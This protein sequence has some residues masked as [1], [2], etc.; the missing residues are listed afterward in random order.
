ME[1]NVIAM[2]GKSPRKRAA[3]KPAAEPARNE[4]VVAKEA[5]SAPAAAVG[6]ADQ[7]RPGRSAVKSTLFAGATVIAL[8]GAA[9]CGRL[10]I[11]S[12]R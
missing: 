9:Y 6:T 1:E 8:A 5:E 11:S 7:K 4:T 10:G 2:N 3:T 12:P